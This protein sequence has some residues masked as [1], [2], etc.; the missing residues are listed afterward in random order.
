MWKV[1][2]LHEPGQGANREKWWVMFVCLTYE[3]CYRVLEMLEFVEKIQRTARQ[4]RKDNTWRIVLILRR[5]ETNL[6][7]SISDIS[8]LSKVSSWRRKWNIRQAYSESGNVTDFLWI[9]KVS[10]W[11]YCIDCNLLF[12]HAMLWWHVNKILYLKSFLFYNRSLSHLRFKF[13]NTLF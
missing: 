7:R 6:F 1:Y 4:E 13:Y 11:Y 3:S 12:C 10:V 9:N 8:Q 5:Y 2:V